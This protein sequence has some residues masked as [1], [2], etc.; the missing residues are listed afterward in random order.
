MIR[1]FKTLAMIAVAVAMMA[2][3][4]LSETR[5]AG[6]VFKDCEHCPEMVVVPS[7]S[8][9]MGSPPSEEGRRNSEGPRHRVTIGSPFA[10]GVYEVTFAEWD[11][12]VRDEG[13]G[14]YSP[15]DGGWGR[16]S[17]PVIY[18]SW[19]DAQSY[20]RWLSRETGEAYRL[21]NESEW[22]YAARAGTETRYWWGDDIGQNRANCHGCGSRWD[23]NRKTARTAPVG[24]FAANA[25]GLH[26]V[27]GNVLE[28]VQ[29]CWWGSYDDALDDGSTWERG[30][31]SRRNR[32]GG[33]WLNGPE[34][35]R[36]ALRSWLVTG[37]RYE[38]VGFRVARTF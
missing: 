33:S 34:D 27:H 20:V 19:D 35:L 15:N 10:V 38:H 37:D 13:C 14:G 3:D 8:F 9:M 28:W 1:S 23:D 4:A 22:E 29:D 18:V 5:E 21:L 11:A 31:C 30:D 7:G 17:R 36:A 12:C 16:E 32:R 6:E 24:S 26:D 25:F 2:G